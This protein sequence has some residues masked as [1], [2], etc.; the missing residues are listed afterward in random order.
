MI[1]FP[2]AWRIAEEELAKISAQMRANER[3]AISGHLVIA[4][5]H[6]WVFFYQLQTYLDSGRDQDQ[7]FGNA[8]F[9]VSKKDGSIHHTGT[10]RPLEEYI[11][12][13][14]KQSAEG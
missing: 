7:L 1:D 6:G 3:V 10:G 5:N 4:G 2:T 13:F 14:K 8:P 11:D 9:I 12:A